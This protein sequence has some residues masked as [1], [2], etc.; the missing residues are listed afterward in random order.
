ME[1]EVATRESRPGAVQ[2]EAVRGPGPD[3]QFFTLIN[4]VTVKFKEPTPQGEHILDKAGLKPPDDYV[5][6][7]NSPSQHPF[8]GAR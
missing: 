5:L 1:K 6:I 4:G 7:Q 2:A 8:G 3:G